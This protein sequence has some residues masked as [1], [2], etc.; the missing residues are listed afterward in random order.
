MSAAQPPSDRQTIRRLL[1]YF[2]AGGEL[3]TLVACGKDQTALHSC[4][5]YTCQPHIAARLL[6]AR[7]DPEARAGPGWTPLDFAARMYA[8]G[9]PEELQAVFRADEEARAEHRS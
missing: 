2:G 3:V 9:V 4:C 5:G 8:E 6:A 7:A 1:S